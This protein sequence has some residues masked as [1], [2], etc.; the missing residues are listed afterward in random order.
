MRRGIGG[1]EVVDV[2]R[3]DE[4]QVPLRGEAGE[5]RHEP[6]LDLQARVLELDVGGVATEDLDEPVELA[7]G[8]GGA[9]L[10]QR[11]ADTARQAAGER[12]Q[13]GRV[14]LEQLPVDP[15]TVVVPLQVAERAELDQVGVALVRLRQDGQVRV[16]L[17]LL[18]AVVDDVH[19]AA[20]DRLD[21]LRLRRLV[22]V[23]RTSQGAMVREGHGGHLE[24]GRLRRER[25]DPARPVE[26]RILGVDVQVDEVGG[27]GRAIVQP[28]PADMVKPAVPLFPLLTMYRELRTMPLTGASPRRSVRA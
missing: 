9:G 3:G 28:A 20:D 27:H 16:T 23:D 5:L 22:E 11:P 18:V 7:L 21:A 14:A 26:D 15:R 17:V 19:L 6:F 25:G 10:G 13:P 1:I 4:R 8:V 12:D 24:R 2:A